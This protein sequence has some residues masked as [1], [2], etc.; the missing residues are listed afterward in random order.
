MDGVLSYSAHI[1]IFGE[2]LFR[3]RNFHKRNHRP[4]R[5]PSYTVIIWKSVEVANP[6]SD[7]RPSRLV[8]SDVP[9]LLIRMRYITAESGLRSSASGVE[10]E[11]VLRF[12]ALEIVNGRIYSKYARLF[13]EPSCSKNPPTNL[14]SVKS[15]TRSYHRQI[16][17]RRRTAGRRR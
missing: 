9:C 8:G 14:E 3:K 6:F 15:K 11:R 16:E 4:R 1:Q 7:A 2:E 10:D 13:E 5:T 12:S 17:S